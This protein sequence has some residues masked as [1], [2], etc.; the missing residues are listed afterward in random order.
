MKFGEFLSIWK[1][2]TKRNKYIILYDDNWIIQD[3]KNLYNG[4]ICPFK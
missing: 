2:F 1:H 3:T 4:K